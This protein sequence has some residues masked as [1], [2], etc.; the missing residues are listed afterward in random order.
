MDHV[1]FVG[2]RDKA[3]E[4]RLRAHIDIYPGDIYSAG[5]EKAAF[6][7]LKKFGVIKDSI[8]VITRGLNPP[9]PAL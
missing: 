7:Q 8:D 9:E 6:A 3:E 5:K 1:R 4:E 2:C